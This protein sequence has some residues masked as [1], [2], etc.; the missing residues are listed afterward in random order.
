M[1]A[2]VKMV[3]NHGNL[4]KILR[5]DVGDAGGVVKATAGRIETAASKGHAVAFDVNRRRARAAVI[6]VTNG[7]KK[8]EATNRNLT[9]AVDAGR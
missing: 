3:T 2:T 4:T 7:A 1:G 8:A 5:G 9:R 6:T